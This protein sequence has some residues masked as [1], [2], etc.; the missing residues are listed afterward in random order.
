M[1]VNDSNNFTAHSYPPWANCFF[2]RPGSLIF[3]SAYITKILILLPLC[4]FVLYLGFQRC[5]QR[6]S[7][8]AA[9]STNSH[10]DIFTFQMVVF[11]LWQFLG[12]TLFIYAIYS[13]N[14]KIFGVGSYICLITRY[15]R[16]SCHVLTCVERYLAVV[17]P[18]TY[19][20][21]KGQRGVR[22]RNIC[23]GLAVLRELIRPGPG[24]Q[25]GDRKRVDQS[26]RR[27]FYTIVA[28]LGVQLLREQEN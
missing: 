8:S 14:H 19:L 17:H 10:S 7:T 12:S 28:I 24:E 20:N 26:K 3:T 1:A 5:R 16:N 25:G 6:S 18:V 15:G 4:I 27:A 23:I 13:A 22:I 11:E 21:L 2:N 9:A